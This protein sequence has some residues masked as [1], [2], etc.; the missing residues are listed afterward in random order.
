[1]GTFDDLAKQRNVIVTTY[2][3]DGSAVA[4]P[5]NI[6]VIGDR[7][8]FRTWAT[9]GKAKR[10]RRDSR[11]TIAPATARGKPAGP[12]ISAT[13]RLLAPDEVPPVRRALSKKY[14]IQQG[15]LVPLIHRLR[16]YETVHYELSAS[17]SLSPP[18]SRSRVTPPSRRHGTG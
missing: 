10:L 7:A 14:P 3:R 18:S 17:E 16:H 15:R 13:A 8:Y 12:S 2:K 4:T 1:M 6:V 5:V 11:V 9:A